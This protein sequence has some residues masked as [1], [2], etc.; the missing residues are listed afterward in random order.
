MQVFLAGRLL[1]DLFRYRSV[2]MSC[3]RLVL[4]LDQACPMRFLNEVIS[5]I[6]VFGSL[7]DYRL[8]VSL[9]VL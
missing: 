1:C 7:L 3:C 6:D 4:E 2:L 9:I 8:S 5:D